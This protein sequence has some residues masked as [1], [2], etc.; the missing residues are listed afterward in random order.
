M[1]PRLQRAMSL[2]RQTSAG[3][4]LASM[5][6]SHVLHEESA[7]DF[8]TEPDRRIEA[9]IAEAIAAEFPGDVLLGEEGG[10]RLLGAG[11]PTQCSLHRRSTGWHVQLR[12]RL[13]V[14]RSIAIEAGGV[15]QCGLSAIR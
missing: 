8:A 15:A 5:P 3:I 2:I 6:R 12:P 10:E 9:Q 7:N 13:S 11:A 4:R 14:H 1:N